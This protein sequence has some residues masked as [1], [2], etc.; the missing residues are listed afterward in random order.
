MII[1]NEYKIEA[2]D[3]RN[4][5]LIKIGVAQKGKNIGEQTETTIGYYT[6]TKQA[7]KALAKKEI[8]GTGLKD[9]ETVNAKIELLYKWIEEAK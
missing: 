1:N 6:D 8:L 9:L 7:L 2:T 3:D 5:S 4:I